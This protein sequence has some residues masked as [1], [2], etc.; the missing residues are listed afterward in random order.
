MTLWRGQALERADHLE[1][2]RTGTPHDWE[3][4]ERLKAQQA[5]SDA[6]FLTRVACRMRTTLDDAAEE[7]GR[8]G[9]P[10]AREGDGGE[11]R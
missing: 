11:K 2:P 1:K 8:P 10:E 7:T 6:E 9:A 3:D 4:W 5:S